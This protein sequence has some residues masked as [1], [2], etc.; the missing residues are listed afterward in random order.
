MTSPGSIPALC[1]GARQ[2]LR[3][4]GASAIFQA[5]RFDFIRRHRPHRHADLAARDLARAQPRQHVA[6]RIDRHGEPDA[7]VARAARHAAIAV[8]RRV[9]ADDL[10]AKV[11]QR[12]AGVAG[13]DRRVR[14]KHVRAALLRNRERPAGRADDADA[15]G[16]S[17]VERI[18]DRHDPVAR[19]HLAGVAELGHRQI[20][21]GLFDEL[22]QRA[23]GQRI[24]ANDLG[25]VIIVLVIEELH[26]DLRRPLDDVVVGDDEAIFRD[27][28]AR[29]GGLRQALA[30]AG[31]AAAAPWPFGAWPAPGPKKRSSKSSPPPPKNSL[32]SCVR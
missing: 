27:D 10:A 3:Y 6:N 29:T 28:E 16:M 20:A 32:R 8:N 30:A 21:V 15:D 23:V 25:L 12:S 9:D 11:E 5:E 26:F 24:P 22:K 4:H 2:H 19:L 7:D 14:L 13:I 17:K 18:A 31:A 1:A